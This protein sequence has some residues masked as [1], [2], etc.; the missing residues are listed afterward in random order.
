MT[1]QKFSA[2]LHVTGSERSVNADAGSKRLVEKLS[3]SF[4]VC[5]ARPAGFIISVRSAHVLRG[6]ACAAGG[7]AQKTLRVARNFRGRQWGY[8][9]TPSSGERGGHGVSLGPTRPPIESRLSS[10]AVVGQGVCVTG[11]SITWA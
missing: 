9:C 10:W 6:A 3:G 8:S 7:A 5:G 2:G 11:T 4:W 1:R